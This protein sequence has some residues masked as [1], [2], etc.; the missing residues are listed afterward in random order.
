[1][2]EVGLLTYGTAQRLQVACTHPSVALA[3][4]AG[5]LAFCLQLSLGIN[6][7]HFYLD[8]Q[9]AIVLQ[10]PHVQQK[11]QQKDG[12]RPSPC[13]CP[14]HPLPHRHCS[15]VQQFIITSTT[16]LTVCC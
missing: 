15:R 3:H 10:L 14:N 5:G 9:F 4:E 13:A 8:G 16:T 1:M 2:Q 6:S 7:L 11:T 12:D